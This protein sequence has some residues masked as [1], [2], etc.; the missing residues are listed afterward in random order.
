MAH[1]EVHNHT[2]L[3]HALVPLIDEHGEPVV[4]PLVQA[5]F[6]IR[7]DGALALV[8]P[9]PG[10]ELAGVEHASPGENGWLIEPQAAFVKPGCDVVV[11]GYAVAPRPGTTSMQVQVRVGALSQRALVFGERRLLRGSR[12]TEPQPFERVPLLH[13]EAFGGWDRRHADPLRHRCHPLNPAGR[14][15]RDPDLPQDDDVPMPAI[16]HPDHLFQR[17]GE[18]PPPVGFGFVPPHWQTRT[19]WAGTYD[20][21]WQAERAPL[22]PA[23]FDRR[24]FLAGST[25]LVQAE[26]LVG[27]EAVVLEGLSPAGPIGF[28]LPALGRVLC[29]LH[30]RGRRQQTLRLQLDTVVIDGY[31]ATLRLIWRAHLPLRLGVMGLVAAEFHLPDPS[32]APWVRRPRRS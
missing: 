3:A 25:G 20:E 15:W 1:P 9:Q 10:I 19:R 22:L 16:E 12:I 21:R 24:C 2:A 7:R 32:A 11:N 28:A 17:Y 23:D 4:V 29:N 26:P 6:R 13:S 18:Q 31:T 8:D 5:S 14:G 27:G 30:L